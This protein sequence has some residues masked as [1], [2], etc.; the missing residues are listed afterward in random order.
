[1]WFSKPPSKDFKDHLL[2]P[3]VFYYLLNK[4]H[5]IIFVFSPP[6]LRCGLTKRL[7]KRCLTVKTQVWDSG[8]GR[9]ALT[10]RVAIIRCPTSSDLLRPETWAHV[11][12]HT[13]QHTSQHPQAHEHTCQHPQISSDLETWAHVKKW[14]SWSVYQVYEAFVQAV[15]HCIFYFFSWFVDFELASVLLVKIW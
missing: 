11:S 6:S 3:V 10:G 8:S 1:M 7:F 15:S 14:R 4:I 9:P 13:S 2:I 12:T 5:F